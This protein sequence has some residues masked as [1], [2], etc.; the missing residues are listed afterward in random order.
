MVLL[1][2]IF[3]RYKF[4]DYDYLEFLTLGN[5]SALL[6]M[7][8]KNGAILCCRILDIFQ[9]AARKR[10]SNVDGIDHSIPRVIASCSN[11][12]TLFGASLAT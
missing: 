1:L 6:F 3:G 5:M 10:V 11:S 4:D 9:T 8:L 7:T 2:F 12:Q